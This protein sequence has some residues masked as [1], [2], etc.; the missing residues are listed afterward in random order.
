MEDPDSDQQKKL[1]EIYEEGYNLYEEILHTDQPTNSGDIQVKIRRAMKLF[2]DATRLASISSLFSSNESVDEVATNDL[3][4]FLLPALLGELT[5]K[6]SVTDRT[7]VVDTADIYFRDFL[8]RCKDYG[9]TDVE[10]PM[11]AL[12]TE[13]QAPVVA[14]HSLTPAESLKKA[15]QSR[16]S[17]IQQ[18]NEQ[19]ALQAELKAMRQHL[20][21]SVDD[22]LKRKYYM[23]L[24]KCHINDSFG[25]L[26]SLQS[27][28]EI[29]KYMANIRPGGSLSASNSQEKLPK[30][31]KP[32]PLK[33]IILTKDEVQKKVFGLGYPSVP[34][35]T[36]KEFYDQCVK[37]GVFPDADTVK[38]RSLQDL[39]SQQ[40]AEAIA[41]QEAAA[42]ERLVE[43]DD[44]ETLARAR[45]VDEY[46]D[47]HRRGWGNRYNRS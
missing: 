38:A 28:K 47:T 1:T 37:D 42:L 30:G 31:P 27:E 2:E 32:K 24:I 4:Y 23:T 25:E 11:P 43:E 26:D 44:D 41:D 33:P 6:L 45:A 3:K 39:A 35:M 22:E 21:S 17:K 36:V 46:K 34:T 14:A 15:A 5:Q 8:Q 13:E 10:V 29:L 9:I 40:N 18:F 7:E 19:K 16:A 12:E 20:N